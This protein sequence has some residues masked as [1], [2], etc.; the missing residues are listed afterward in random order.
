MLPCG[1][2]RVHKIP[3]SAHLSIQAFEEI[4][5]GYWKLVTDFFEMVGHLAVIFHSLAS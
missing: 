4:G 2:G 5:F 3:G 1:S